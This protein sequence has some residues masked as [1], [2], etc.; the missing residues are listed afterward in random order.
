MSDLPS[1]PLPIVERRNHKLCKFY[2]KYGKCREGDNCTF[3]HTDNICPDYFF[4]SACNYTEC[5]LSHTF[6]VKKRKELQPVNEVKKQRGVK[7]DEK[8]EYS[9]G[10]RG[11]KNTESFVPSDIPAD[12]NVKIYTSS[13]RYGP[14]D[15]ILCSDLFNDLGDVYENLLKEVND[16]T[17][18]N[19]LWKL[20]HGDSHYIADDKRNFKEKSPLFLEIIRRISHHFKMDVKATRLNLYQ[21][22]E[23]WKPY[24]FD[25]AAVDEKKSKTQNFTIGV[26]FG[27]TREVSFQHSVKRDGSKGGETRATVNFELLNGMTYGFGSQVN[28]E[29]RHGIPLVKPEEYKRGRISVIAWGWVDM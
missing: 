10:K 20:W 9:K 4:N 18:P 1:V 26:S 8:D 22:K 11:K 3:D 2:V 27:D 6:T 21:D 23:E 29:W 14:S 28:V 12:M 16:G 17:D 25:A 24:H 19:K 15:V 7:K 5:K 13:T